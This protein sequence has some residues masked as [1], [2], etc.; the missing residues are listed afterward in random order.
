VLPEFCNL[1]VS[2]RWVCKGPVRVLGRRRVRGGNCQALKRLPPKVIAG[3]LRYPM[4]YPIKTTTWG[5]REKTVRQDPLTA[6]SHCGRHQYGPAGGLVRGTA[7]G[8]D[9]GF[10]FCQ[11][12]SLGHL[13]SPTVSEGFLHSSK[14]PERYPQFIAGEEYRNSVQ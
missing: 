9:T 10:P 2:C 14:H 12:S 11:A 13:G 7:P 3:L 8:Q 6:P 4:R 1:V 5:T